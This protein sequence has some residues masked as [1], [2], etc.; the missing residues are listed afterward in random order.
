[1]K[2]KYILI[3]IKELTCISVRLYTNFA[4]KEN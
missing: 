2:T 1:M 3:F 4:R